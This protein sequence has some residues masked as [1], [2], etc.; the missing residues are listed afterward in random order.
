MENKGFDKSVTD[1]LVCKTA[2][3]I[4]ILQGNNKIDLRKPQTTATL[5]RLASSNALF[6]LKKTE[7]PKTEKA[8]VDK[9]VTKKL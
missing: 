7:E 8:A 2:H 3:P 1:V 6:E 4:W 9:P 5:T